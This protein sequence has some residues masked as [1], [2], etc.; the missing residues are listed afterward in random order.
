IATLRPGSNGRMKVGHSQPAQLRVPSGPVLPLSPDIHA[1]WATDPGVQI[2]QH[3]RRLAEAEITSPADQVSRQ[4]RD[5]LRQTDTERPT[6]QRPDARLE[7]LQG[8]RADL[9][10]RLG[11]VRDR[12]SQ[13]LSLPASR[14]R[15]LGFVD[16]E[17]ESGR[18]EATGAL[19]DS[20]SRP[21]AAHVD[22]A[23]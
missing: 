1:Q 18:Q 15:A 4:G 21:T 13:E 7:L 19:H 14:H 10:G 20:L 11:L 22:V 12:E 9:P 3:D 6:G 23:V 2:P 16:L 8:L 5:Q 17:L